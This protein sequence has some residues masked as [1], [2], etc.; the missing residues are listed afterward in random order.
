MTTK[1]SITPYLAEYLIGK[2]NNG[3]IEAVKFSDES[4]IYHSIWELMSR[5]PRNMSCVDEG[6]LE[7]WLPDRRVGK[8]P[9]IY[10]YLSQKSASML[11]KKIKREFDEE[12]HSM[13]NDNV[14]RGKPYDNIEVIHQFMCSYCIE[15]V[16]EDALQKN[17]YRW[18]E[19]IRKKRIRR[20]YKKKLNFSE[21]RTDRVASF[22]R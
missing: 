6:N 14:E 17:Y 11:E 18:K 3:S 2:Y 10:N 16:S 7:I 22:V 12:L 9:K 15:S 8:D 4:D 5:R 21:K 19:C 13:I 20:E 1:I